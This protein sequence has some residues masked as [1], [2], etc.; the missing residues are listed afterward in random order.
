MSNVMAALPNVDGAICLTP[1]TGWRPLLECRAVM[2]PRR[3][4]QL[5]YAGEPQT[6]QQ[7]SAASACGED[8][9]V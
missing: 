1:Q 4:K 2:L 9:G 5:K 3:K 6:R 8:I 7:M